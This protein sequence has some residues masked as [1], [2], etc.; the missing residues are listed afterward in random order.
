MCYPVLNIGAVAGGSAAP[1]LAS[2]GTVAGDRVFA[3]GFENPL[4][5]GAGEPWVSATTA[6][7]PTASGGSSLLYLLQIHNANKWAGWHI[8]FGYD[9]TY[10]GTSAQWCVISNFYPQPGAVPQLGCSLHLVTS[11]GFSSYTVSSGD[12][13]AATN[14][15]Y[16]QVLLTGTSVAQSNFTSVPN[17]FYPALGAIFPPVATYP[18]RLDNKVAVASANNLPVQSVGNIVC[19]NTIPTTCTVYD[20]DDNLIGNISSSSGNLTQGQLNIAYTVTSDTVSLNP[21]AYYVSP[22]GGTML[23]GSPGLVGSNFS[24]APSPMLSSSTPPTLS[25]TGANLGFTFAQQAGGGA[26][27]PGTATCT[28]TFTTGTSAPF[29][30]SNTQTFTISMMPTTATHFSVTAP[31]T[32]NAGSP[33]TNAITVTA[34]DAANHVVTTFGDTVAFSSST[35]S[36]AVLPGNATLMNGTGTFTATFKTSGSQTI[37]VT[38]TTTPSIKGTSA[39]TTVAPGAATKYVL[40]APSSATHGVQTSFLIMAQDAY[41]NTA[42]GYTGTVNFTSSDTSAVFSPA[43]TTL[44][45]NTSIN[46]TFVTIGPQTITATDTPNSLTQTSSS[47]TVN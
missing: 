33:M 1:V 12:I 26:Y 38:D 43:S 6:L 32:A 34:L 31:T 21:V 46:V 7:S 5:I 37:T 14:S 36:Q 18:Q 22:T 8:D 28:A 42:T 30:L 24:C 17:T 39:G 2:K 44:S 35:D 45:G 11:P 13:Q 20:A 41:G 29:A 3:E 10:F 23:P 19:A 9:T 16:L 25:A 4:S 27:V 47:I 15:V 40:S